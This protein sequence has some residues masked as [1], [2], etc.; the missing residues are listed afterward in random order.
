M[1]EFYD[2]FDS[3]TVP[4]CEVNAFINLKTKSGEN[5][6]AK[7]FSLFS[8]K[9]ETKTQ[10]DT[11]THFG[12]DASQMKTGFTKTN[13]SL[14][15]NESTMGAVQEFLQVLKLNDFSET[16]KSHYF[17]NEISKYTDKYKPGS[18]VNSFNLNLINSIFR[19]FHLMFAHEDYDESGKKALYTR[20][21][22]NIVLDSKQSALGLD[23]LARQTELGFTCSGVRN[24]H[25]VA[26]GES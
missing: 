19:G 11:T 23:V 25:K 26:G 2:A 4:G 18:S 13:G 20:E 16:K 22:Y 1:N 9:Y 3:A 5:V 8:A 12:R 10:A 14:T 24:F 21:I 17:T 7:I 6:R 15:F